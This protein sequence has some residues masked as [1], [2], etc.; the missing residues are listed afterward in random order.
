CEWPCREPSRG[1]FLA[2]QWFFCGWCRDAW[3]SGSNPKCAAREYPDNY[4]FST[5]ISSPPKRPWEIRW[6]KH[7]ANESIRC[8]PLSQGLL[9]IR[10]DFVF[11]INPNRNRLS[12]ER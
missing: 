5:P 7:N 8:R 11:C 6:E 10:Q 4:K 9:I 12:P 3:I 1:R 2:N